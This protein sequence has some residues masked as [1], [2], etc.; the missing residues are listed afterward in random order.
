MVPITAEIQVNIKQDS[1]KILF[2]ARFR[3]EGEC[4]KAIYALL[5]DANKRINKF[6]KRI[7]WS[8]ELEVSTRSNF[9][10]SITT[11]RPNRYISVYVLGP[12][13]IASI[14]GFIK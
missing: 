10:I 8:I 2:V 5:P 4:N 9:V 6:G 12:N 13:E 14:W 7:K 11:E 1:S 3:V